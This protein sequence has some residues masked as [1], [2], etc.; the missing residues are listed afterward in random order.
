MKCE[1]CPNVWACNMSY[2]WCNPYKLKRQ[3]KFATLMTYAN[4]G[5]P[6]GE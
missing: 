5:K 2:S 3:V 4:V 6:K 1:G